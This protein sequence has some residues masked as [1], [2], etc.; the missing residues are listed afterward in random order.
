M[1]M[2]AVCHGGAEKG[3]PRTLP[4]YAGAEVMATPP[5]IPPELPQKGQT[6]EGK[7]LIEEAIGQGGMGIVVAARHMVLGQRVAIKFILDATAQGAEAGERL[8][9]EARAA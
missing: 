9:R 5:A 8:L 7:F 2:G 1:A 3:R 6:L 4:C